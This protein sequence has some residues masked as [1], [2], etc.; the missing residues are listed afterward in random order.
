MGADVHTGDNDALLSAAFRRHVDIIIALLDHNANIS[1]ATDPDTVV[2]IF[3]CQKILEFQKK[4]QKK[5][6]KEAQR[7]IYFWMIEKLYKPKT[8]SCR[9]LLKKKYAEM[10][11]I[12]MC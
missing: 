10:T 8:E 11:T 1:S 7:K 4:I 5:R 3:K 2:F 6:R 12:N 9:S